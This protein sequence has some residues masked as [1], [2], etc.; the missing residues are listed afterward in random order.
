MPV[1]AEPER[2]RTTR[3]VSKRCPHQREL[4]RPKDQDTEIEPCEICAEIAR[5]LEAGEIPF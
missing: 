2:V 4:P 5:M 1:S 3:P